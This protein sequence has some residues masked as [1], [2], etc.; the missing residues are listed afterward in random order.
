MA[1]QQPQALIFDMD[2]TIIDNMSFHIESWIAFFA[3][4]GVPMTT[5]DVLRRTDG[6]IEEALRRNLG[7]QLTADELAEFGERKE[8]LY[9][10]LYRPH[11]KPVAGL[12]EF[13]RAAQSRDIPV[14][15]GTSAGPRNIEFALEGLNL[16]SA[17]A[18]VVGGHEVERGK[19][20][21][22]TFL[23]VA[24]LLQVPAGGCVVFEDSFAGLEAARRAGMSSVALA[25]T[26]SEEKLRVLPGV[27]RVI[28]DY[29]ELTDEIF[30][31][32]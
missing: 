24:E 18:V 27:I 12:N 8:S 30:I 4:V 15:M 22:D 1:K 10:E 3:S 13:L 2:G 16:K 11:L 21:P 28:K 5:E 26:H 14:A 19:P 7:E 25:T 32:A 29:T 31:P 20:H 6:T 17:F 9:R 23:A